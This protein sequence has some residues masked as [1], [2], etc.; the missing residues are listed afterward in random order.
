LDQETIHAIDLAFN[1]FV[2]FV[3]QAKK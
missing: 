2:K 1:N 3:E